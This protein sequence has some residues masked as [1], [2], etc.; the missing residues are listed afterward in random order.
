V[1]RTSLRFPGQY[2]DAETDFF[3]NWNRYYDSSV[4]R[5]LQPDPKLSAKE[6]MP[7]RTDVDSLTPVLLDVASFERHAPLPIEP[8]PDYLRPERRLFSAA[9]TPYTYAEANPSYFVD[10]DGRDP[11]SICLEWAE[12]PDLVPECPSGQGLVVVCRSVNCLDVTYNSKGKPIGTECDIDHAV[13]K[14]YLDKCIP[15]KECATQFQL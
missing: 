6:W 4:G 12:G 15:R 10:P 13:L 14:R 11:G 8:L 9:L 2:A 5:Y 3:E 1:N 7:T